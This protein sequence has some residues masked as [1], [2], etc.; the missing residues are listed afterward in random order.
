MST[1]LDKLAE[2]GLDAKDAQKLH[3]E[4]LSK[5]QTQAL[6]HDPVESIKINY[7]TPAGKPMAGW[8]KAPQFYRVRLLKAKGPEAA[9][10]KEPNKYMQGKNTATCA[11]F[12]QNQDWNCLKDDMALIITEGEFK[13]ACACKKGFPTIG[14]GGVYNFQAVRKG[15]TFLPELEAINWVQRNVYVCFDSDYKTNPMVCSALKSLGE[16]LL[17]RGAYVFVVELPALSATK[18]TGLDDFLVDQGA[19]AFEE[20]L[21]NAQPIGLTRPLFDLNDKYIY[22]ENPGIVVNKQTMVK[23]NPG[24]F[25]DH[26]EAAKTYR[27]QSITKDGDIAIKKVAAA[28]AWIS[29]PLR[30]GASSITYDPGKDSLVDGKLNIWP[31]WG[32]EPKKGDV[33]PWLALVDHLFQE[34][35]PSAKE[36]FLDW[37]ACPVQRP[38]LKMFTSVLFHGITHGTGKTLVGKTLGRI[39]GKN[40]TTIKAGD[41]HGGFNEWAEGRQFVMGD[42]VAG[43][44]KREDNDLLKTLVTQDEIRVNV[45]YVP[46]YTIPDRINYFF[47]SNH[48]DAFFLEDTD[49]RFFINEVLSEKKTQQFYTDYVKLLDNVGSAFLFDWLRMC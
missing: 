6:G 32:C 7:F 22:I 33:G 21:H 15:I 43:S 8:P 2:S 31:G 45:K 49:R 44:N 40:Y 36:W 19:K 20:L 18:K 10:G 42:D 23:V 48:P 16:E 4:F 25:R 24:A 17:E 5:A 28:K 38:G 14:L 11:Y 27:E 41:L 47:N 37:C 30:A 39:Y 26:L 12:P 35:E 13:A 34:T 9:T 46:S 29:W 3:M 1:Q